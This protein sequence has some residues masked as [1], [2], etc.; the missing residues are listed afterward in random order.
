MKIAFLVTGS[1]GSFYCSN[2]YR[3][4][5]YFRAVKMAEGVTGAAIPLYLPPEKIYSDSG[6]DSNVFFGAISLY[7]R[8]KVSFLE[9]MP[10]FIDKILDSPPLL[11]IAAR[12]AGT[13]RTEGL[14]H[15]TLNMIDS[16]QSSRE[17]EVGRLVNYL[18]ATGKPDVIHLSNALIIGLARQIKSLID[19]KVVCSL[20]NEDDWIN[21]MAEPFQSMAWK[22]I[23][24]E[25]VNIDA[26]IS[27]S[28]Y[29]KDFFISKT[30]VTADKITVVSSGIETNEVP[31]RDRKGGIPAIGFFS[32]VSRHNGFDKIV[33][34]FIAIKSGRD[35]SDLTLHVCGGYTSDDKPFISEQIRKIKDQGFKSSV[36]I[37]PEFIGSAKYNFLSSIDV[38]SVPVRKH[39]AY[40]LYI[41]E[42]NAAGIPVVQPATGAFPE[43]VEM[44]GGGI[45]YSP[46]T[47]DE[48]ASNIRKL[49]HDRVLAESYGR[50]GSIAVKEK[51]TLRHMSADLISMYKSLF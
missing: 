3:D 19:V 25:S 44:T 12:Q 22:M 16:H 42:S 11:R 49:L 13:T 8:E 14:E 17:R 29:Y 26:F 10:S 47:S 5:L 4:M 30:G 15:L 51:F 34:A 24:D 41:L 18:I 46:D 39:D 2:C 27:P 9:Q 35:F 7:L 28:R 48:L 50:A 40:G 32:R 6:F 43:I 31:V 1:G 23:A 20:Q 38:M 21:E 37:Y 45:I 36:H 33:D